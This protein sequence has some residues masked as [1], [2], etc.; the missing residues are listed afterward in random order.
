MALVDYIHGR[1][2]CPRCGMQQ[3][4]DVQFWYGEPRQHPY[5]MGDEMRWAPVTAEG[6]RFKKVVADGM[7]A[8]PCERCQLG[9]DTDEEWNCYVHIDNN[10][11]VKI[12]NSDGNIDF[13]GEVFVVLADS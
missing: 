5:A 1:L 4:I 6:L 11:I 9:R 10:R 12:S 2:T 3:Q 8:T 13:G 7:V